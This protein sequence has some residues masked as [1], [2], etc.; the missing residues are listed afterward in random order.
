MVVDELED[1]CVV[2]FSWFYDGLK[3]KKHLYREKLRKVCCSRLNCVGFRV[4]IL[5]VDNF[6]KQNDLKQ[7][8]K[9]NQ[10][11]TISVSLSK[12]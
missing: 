5:T 7:Q 4:R 10:A 9:P 8:H 1:I 3:H 6:S 12:P 11:Q 2:L